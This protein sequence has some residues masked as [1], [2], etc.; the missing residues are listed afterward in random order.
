VPQ[1]KVSGMTHWTAT[2]EMVRDAGGRLTISKERFVVGKLD[3]EDTF[4]SHGSFP[5]RESLI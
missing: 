5:K 3:P 4:I 1:A 2:Y